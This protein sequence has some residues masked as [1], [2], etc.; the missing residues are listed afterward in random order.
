MSKKYIFAWIFFVVT[1][2]GCF[3]YIGFFKN[4]QY[5]P[6]YDLESSL[7]ESASIY[8]S[9]NG[10]ELVNGDSMK[11]DIKDLVD[12]GFAE[13][14]NVKDDKCEGYVLISKDNNKVKYKTYLT[15][16]TY[17]TLKE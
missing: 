17:K 6:Y 11:V 7:E 14:S 3:L 16:S 12:S 1:L 5:K 10:F 4:K 15:C 2:L 13:K 9:T 8:M